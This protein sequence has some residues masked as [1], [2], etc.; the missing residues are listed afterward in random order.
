MGEG[1]AG[2]TQQALAL[3]ETLTIGDV[4]VWLRPAGHVLGSAQVCDGMPGRRAPWS[5]A[6]TSAAADPTC[7]G[8]EPEPCD[9][10]VTEATFAL[11][12]FRH[13][14]PEHE[15][16]RLLRQRRAVPG[17]HARRR[18]LRARQMPAADRP[19][20]PGRLGPADLAARRAC[21]AVPGL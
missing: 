1:R 6:T 5:A 16:A 10:F 8:F 9:V 21:R 19:A 17:A 20:A 2:Q 4:R 3:G 15:I 7:A 14:P 12:V 18:L 11:P 13:P